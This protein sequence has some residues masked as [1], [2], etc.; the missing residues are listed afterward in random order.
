MEVSVENKSMDDTNIEN[1]NIGDIADV[2][3]SK[4]N[5][6][7]TD[8]IV[9][10][11]IMVKSD[12]MSNAD[13]IDIYSFIGDSLIKSGL[14][15]EKQD[16]CSY[17][18]LTLAY[19]GDAIYELIIRSMIV[20]E[21]NAPVNKMHKRSSSFVKAETQ[22]EFIKYML[23]NELLSE[24]EMRIYKRGRNAQSYTK[25]K[26]ASVTDYRMATGFEALVGYLYLSGQSERMMELVGKCLGKMI[27]YKE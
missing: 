7:D 10:V 14:S 26:N 19:I 13:N 22:A 20:T 8:N 5:M 25:A 2:I 9:D 24:E 11:D 17:S 16:I 21:G 3:D 6:D 18:P 12:S 1:A 15:L 27:N 23:D 4:V